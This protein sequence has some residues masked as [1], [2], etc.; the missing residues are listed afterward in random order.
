MLHIVV[1]RDE[2]NAAAAQLPPVLPLE[3][4]GMS[5]RSF[6]AV[7]ASQ[8]T[9]L[10]KRYSEQK[11]NKI[12]EQFR[13]LCLKV[14]EDEQFRLNLQ[15]AAEKATK[16]SQFEKCWDVAGN[17]FG[18][19]RQYC[20]GIASVMAGT[21]SVESDFSRINWIKD[22]HSSSMT[23]FTL[24]SILQCGQHDILSQLVG[25]HE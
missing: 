3:I 6:A 21:A 7:L 12:S 14:K 20:G 15:A 1:E 16:V 4:A 23:D 24:E 9:R 8:K 11:F 17:E 13:D 19:L 10:L 5:P 2:G 22:A 25:F 18:Y